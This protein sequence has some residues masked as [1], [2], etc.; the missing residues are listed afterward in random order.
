ME[1]K[2]HSLHYYLLLIGIVSLGIVIFFT[3]RSFNRLRHEPFPHPRKSNVTL[4]QSWM[5]LDYV[6]HSYLVPGDELGKRLHIDFAANR[7]RSLGSIAKG[8]QQD[9]TQFILRVQQAV[10]D[11]QRTHPKAP[12]H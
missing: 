10:A 9:T 12:E 1:H 3:I 2:R 4:I 6:S 8:Q 7:K 5:T 11:F